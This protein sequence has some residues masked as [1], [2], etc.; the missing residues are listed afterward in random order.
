MG[1]RKRK[2]MTDRAW[3]HDRAWKREVL[4]VVRFETQQMTM[5]G[6]TI[7]STSTLPSLSVTFSVMV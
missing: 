3:K 4:P 5:I 6:I 2:S 1:F 7:V